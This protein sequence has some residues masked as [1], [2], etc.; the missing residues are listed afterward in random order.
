MIRN[1]LLWA[2]VLTALAAQEEQQEQ[3]QAPMETEYFLLEDLQIKSPLE[4]GKRFLGWYV[5]GEW[6]VQEKQLS[7]MNYNPGLFLLTNNLRIGSSKIFYDLSLSMNH[8]NPN[9]GGE[10]GEQSEV[11][12][13]SISNDLYPIQSFNKNSRELSLSGYT[14]F[15]YR[16][17]EKFLFFLKI[18][19]RQVLYNLGSIRTEDFTKDGRMF[20]EYDY[21]DKDTSL[22]FLMDFEAGNFHVF[23]NDHVCISYGID[24]NVF[25]EDEDTK[26]T[27][28][29][30]GGFSSNASPIRL[31]LKSLSI[32]K[33]IVKNANY[34]KFHDDVSK[35]SS[36]MEF[37]DDR[38]K[39]NK[40][41]SNIMLA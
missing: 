19:Q 30:V 31:D 29:T 40:S 12:A 16:K 4:A 15:V 33:L 35:F 36:A 1:L 23:I 34:L 39:E 20:C 7:F 28:L 9:S 5:D 8:S 14:V 26:R 3:E 32:Y 38:A 22:K 21:L 6:Q 2:A 27:V 10:V 13:F 17:R 18:F 25:G 37:Y 24:K 11:L 41:L